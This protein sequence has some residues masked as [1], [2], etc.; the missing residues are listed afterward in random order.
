MPTL[1]HAPANSPPVWPYSLA[2]LRRDNLNVSFSA[3]PTADDL[4]PFDVFVV[5]PTDPPEH[6]PTTHRAQEITPVEIDGQ[7]QQAWELIELPPAPPT[8]DWSTFKGGL[9]TS[10]AVAQVMGAARE[11]GCE[12]AV[13]NLPAALEKAQ[14]GDTAEFVACWGLV[15]AAGGASPDALAALSAA[16]QACNLPAEFVAAVQP[17]ERANGGTPSSSGSLA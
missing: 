14:S 13:T 16:A 1:L 9:L 5:E 7:W 11:A 12:P 4:A 10:A 3:N 6:D 17:L 2:D 8:P 15:V